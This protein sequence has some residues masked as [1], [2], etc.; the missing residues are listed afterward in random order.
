MRER[1]IHRF[2]Q[3]RY[4]QALKPWDRLVLWAMENVGYT[5]AARGRVTLREGNFEGGNFEGG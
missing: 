4:W 1:E 3:E 2:G 5:G